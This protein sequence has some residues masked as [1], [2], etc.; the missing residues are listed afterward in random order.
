MGDE[1]GRRRPRRRGGEAKSERSPRPVNYTQLRHP[2]TAQSAFSEDAVAAMHDTAI[3]ILQELGIKTLLPEAREL[4]RAA[5]ALVD[6]ERQMVRIGRD[7]VDDALR[8]APPS[9]RIRAGNPKRE[10]IYEDGSLMFLPGAGCPNVTDSVRG[11]RPGS[12]RDFKETISLHQAFDVI[13][14]LGPSAEPQDVPVN[15]RH[16]AML[17]TQLSLSDKPTFAYARGKQ[18][19]EECF[20]MIRLAHGLDDA[21]FADDVWIFTIINTNSPRQLDI[22]MSQGLIDFARA[23][24]LSIVTPFC[25]AGAMAPITVA[26]ALT[27]QHSEALAAIALTQLAKPGAP[28]SYGSF[29]SNVDMKSGSPAFGTP[30]HVKA[31]LGAGQL[32]RHIGLPWR[33]ASGSAS[34]ISDAQGAT[35]NTTGAWGC[36]LANATSIVHAAG[37]LEG[38]LAFGYEKFINDIEAIQTLAELCTA[39]PGDDDSIGFDAIA[40]VDPGGHFFASPHTMERYETAFYEP[41]VADLSNFG[42]WTES[43]GL[44]STD[45]AAKIWQTVLGEFKAPAGCAE[46]AGRLDEFIAKGTEA[47][48]APIES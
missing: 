48:G 47:G 12:L 23:G 16:Y 36:M 10:Q 18:Q 8:T 34:N 40:G 30:E 45:R 15:L 25:L 7:I 44:T 11:R 35:E 9:F 27:L 38:G 2:F 37:W 29:S 33:A 24:Q 6:E 4:F 22:P 1:S 39:P 32:A 26:G 41:V 5:G 42:V 13:H 28:V 21:A 31:T 19:A 43:G 17:Q 14:M 3:R 46:R 20:E